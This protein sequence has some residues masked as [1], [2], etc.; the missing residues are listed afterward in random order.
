MGSTLGK[1]R[2]SLRRGVLWLNKSRDNTGIFEA[3]D[4]FVELSQGNTTVKEVDIYPYDEDAWCDE[5]WDKV[6]RGVG[7]LKLLETLRIIMKW[8]INEGDVSNP[9]WEILA[10]IFDM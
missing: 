6:G 10:R 8:E 9:D 4:S 7:N 5:L 1:I 3:V 2:N